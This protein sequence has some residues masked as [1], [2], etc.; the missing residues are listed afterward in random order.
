MASSQR[1][2]GMLDSGLG[3]LT[4]LSALR[5]MTS[6]LEI[7]YFADTAHVPYGDRSLA[8]VASL[9]SR[10]VRRLGAHNPA[11]YVVASGTTCAAFDACGWP[12]SN[13]PFFGIVEPGPRLRE[14]AAS[15]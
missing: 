4:V 8:D 14:P 12:A 6:G 15:A 10:I 13:A 2:V 9:G 1:R 11:L 5:A 3:G 7:I